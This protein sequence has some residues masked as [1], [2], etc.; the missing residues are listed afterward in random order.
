MALLLLGDEERKTERG[1]EDRAWRTDLLPKTRRIGSRPIDREL[2]GPSPSRT[3]QDSLETKLKLRYPGTTSQSSFCNI[4][5][6]S[7]LLHHQL[8]KMS[9]HTAS[10]QTHNIPS[11]S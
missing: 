6:F 3:L 11:Y 9:T 5:L 4:D 10:P 1:K 2:E 7:T 8:K